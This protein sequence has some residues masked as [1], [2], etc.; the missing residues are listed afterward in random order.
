MQAP[1]DFHGGGGGAGI[2]NKSLSYVWT[3]T[4]TTCFNSCLYLQYTKT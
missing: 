3:K 4:T 1:I 2:K